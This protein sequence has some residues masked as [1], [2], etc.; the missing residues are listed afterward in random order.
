MHT[1]TLSFTSIT[2]MSA[3]LAKIVGATLAA[4]PDATLDKVTAGKPKAAPAASAAVAPTPAP[5]VPTPAAA[6]ATA[7]KSSIDYPT[8]QKAV[9][10]LAGA[11]REAA[12]EVSASFGV[13]T[14]K[15]LDASKWDEAL[16]AVNAKIVELETAVA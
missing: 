6:P 11:S 13:K 1:V 9:F 10:K 5:A 12:G 15:D 16:A 3:A 7:A 2:E 8:L 14:F 4:A